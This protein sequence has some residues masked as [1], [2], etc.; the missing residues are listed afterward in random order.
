MWNHDLIVD[1]DGS[2]NMSLQIAE[3]VG[4]NS[5][6]ARI[7]GQVFAAMLAP[8]EPWRES[9]ECALSEFDDDNQSWRD[10]AGYAFN[11]LPDE[12][13]AEAEGNRI[14]A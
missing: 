5:R 2:A 12:L 11:F 7:T 8:Y 13:F 4:V 10:Y 1:G 6:R 14:Q 9:V 3:A